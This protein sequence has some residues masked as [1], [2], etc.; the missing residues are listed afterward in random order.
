[1]SKKTNKSNI[2][3]NLDVL[4]YLYNIDMP[5]NISAKVIG[6]MDLYNTIKVDLDKIVESNDGEEL[7][8]NTQKKIQSFLNEEIEITNPILWDELRCSNILISPKRLSSLGLFI[9]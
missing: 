8:K 5:I 7:T 1:M 6:F 9:Q 3:A 2:L 4:T